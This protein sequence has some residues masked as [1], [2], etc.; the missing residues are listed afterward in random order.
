MRRGDL[1]QQAL[2]K[3]QSALNELDASDEVGLFAFDE[4]MT[5]VVG[6]SI[7]ATTDAPTN[8]ELIRSRAREI[9]PSWRGTH[10]GGAMIEVADLL[11]VAVDGRTTAVR[12]Q[13]IVISDLQ[14]GADLSALEAFRW[15]EEIHV[16]VQSVQPDE[17]SNATLRM[18]DDE[19]ESQQLE[20]PRVR[21]V[22]AENS[23][24]E[25]SLLVGMATMASGW[26][27]QK[28]RFTF[29][30]VKAERSAFL[31]DPSGW[32]PVSFDCAAIPTSSTI[33]ILLRLFSANE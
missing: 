5:P 11:D 18:L 4:S 21:V 16:E 23:V 3:V 1:W 27:R 30:L 2:S 20:E 29:R 32:R 10:L 15:P 12:T 19:Q 8:R 17:S 24:D 26:T 14:S 13:L 9:S 33:D 31:V 6:F 25:Q 28:R 22:N 7:S